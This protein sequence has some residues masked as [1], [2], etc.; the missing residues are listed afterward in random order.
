MNPQYRRVPPRWET[1]ASFPAFCQEAI[2]PNQGRRKRQGREA[3][4]ETTHSS[5]N[6][7]F[8]SYVRADDVSAIVVAYRKSFI[9][10]YDGIPFCLTDIYI[11]VVS[12]WA[13]QEEWRPANLPK[14]ERLTAAVASR[15]K[16]ASVWQRHHA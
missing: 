6:S 4:D 13:Q 11:A 15:P 8:H 9:G 1:N 2:P 5:S 16:C 14:I 3:E 7:N 10:T 12:R